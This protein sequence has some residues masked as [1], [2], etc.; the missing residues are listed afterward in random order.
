MMQLLPMRRISIIQLLKSSTFGV[1]RSETEPSRTASEWRVAP[2]RGT[3][4]VCPAKRV[5]GPGDLPK[6]DRPGPKN[7]AVR[8]WRKAI[9]QE[10]M[11]FSYRWPRILGN[12]C[13]TRTYRGLWRP[14]ASGKS[15]GPPLHATPRSAGTQLERAPTS[16]TGE[17]G[18]VP[19]EVPH[20]AHDAPG[21]VERR[22]ITVR[23]CVPFRGG[24]PPGREAVSTALLRATR[25]SPVRYHCAP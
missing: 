5:P 18:S 7:P 1:R 17:F 25:C 11:Q 14:H 6:Q 24:L 9:C 4:N 13:N 21:E 10:G 20:F 19:G 15:R 8:R 16:P 22:L 3:S 23:G 2:R 12:S